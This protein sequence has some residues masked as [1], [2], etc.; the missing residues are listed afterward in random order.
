[1]IIFN[2]SLSGKQKAE[3]TLSV[4]LSGQAAKGLGF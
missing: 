1:M 2:I 3:R 4:H